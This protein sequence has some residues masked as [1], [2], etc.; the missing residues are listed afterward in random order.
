MLDDSILFVI[1]IVGSIPPIFGAFFA[2]LLEPEPATRVR[3]NLHHQ[4]S[5]DFKTPRL[6]T[7]GKNQKD[8]LDSHIAIKNAWLMKVVPLS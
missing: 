3:I 7:S 8:N 1:S 5:F 6:Q 4:S 2:V